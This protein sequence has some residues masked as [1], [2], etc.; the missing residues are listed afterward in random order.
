VQFNQLYRKP[1][2]GLPDRRQRHGLVEAW[3]FSLSPQMLIATECGAI[4]LRDREMHGI[5]TV[6]SGPYGRPPIF[7]GGQ[8]PRREWQSRKCGNGGIPDFHSLLEVIF[9]PPA[10]NARTP[11]NLPLPDLHGHFHG[12]TGKPDRW[13]SPKSGALKTSRLPSSLIRS[14][15]PR[16][17][18][19]LA[20]STIVT[21]SPAECPVS[22]PLG[23]PRCRYSRAIPGRMTVR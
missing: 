1:P 22:S 15:Q 9:K 13:T 4:L 8:S 20:A 21:M 5:E 18:A 6:V 12:N 23:K 7:S 16:R 11:R 14:S 3:V 10:E 2:S 17:L 19:A